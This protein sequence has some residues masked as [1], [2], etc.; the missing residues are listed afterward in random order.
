MTYSELMTAT[1]RQGLSP[2]GRNRGFLAAESNYG[3][4]REMQLRNLIVPLTGDFAGP[5]TIRAVG[6]YLK[7]H[8][9]TVTA[10]YVSNVETYLLNRFS[11]YMM[12]VEALPTDISS[13]FIRSSAPSFVRI[14][15]PVVPGNAQTLV[16]MLASMVDVLKGYHDGHI[17]SWLDVNNMLQ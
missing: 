6:A 7:D 15:S 10:F 4:V 16:S 13:T 8:G 17:R 2:D 14:E 9:A 5:K 1:D 3:I 11:D 12:N